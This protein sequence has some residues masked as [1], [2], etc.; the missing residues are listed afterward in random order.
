MSVPASACS[1]CCRVMPVATSLKV[2]AVEPER[3]WTWAFA[4][5]PLLKQKVRSIRSAARRAWQSKV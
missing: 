3:R 5:S 1:A 2:G 4:H